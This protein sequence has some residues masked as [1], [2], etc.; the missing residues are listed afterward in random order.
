MINLL[1]SMIRRKLKSMDKWSVI[2]RSLFLMNLCGV[3]PAKVGSKV[4][5]V[6]FLFLIVNF[7]ITTY[8]MAMFF[9][10]KEEKD[11]NMFVMSLANVLCTVHAILYLSCLYYQRP[12][13]MQLLTEMREKFWEIDIYTDKALIEN[14][15]SSLDKVQMKYALFCFIMFYTALTYL[16][17]RILTDRRPIGDNLLFESYV[18]E[19]MSFWFLLAWQH[20]PA[21]AL[22]SIEMAMDFLICSI[23]SLTAQQYRLLRYEMERVF[24]SLERKGDTEENISKRIRRCNDQLTFLLSFRNTLNEAFSYLM[25]AY[26]GV[27]VLILC[28]EVYLLFQMDS[29]EHI[30]KI[31]AYSGFIFFEFFVCYCYPAQ[32]LTV[33]AEQLANSIYFSEWY[34]YPNHCKE[35]LMLVGKSQIRVVF[36]AGGLLE[37]DLPTGMAVSSR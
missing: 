24:G 4:Q 21:G 18:P 13:I 26:I 9:V 3:H 14:Y 37:L 34:K 8:W 27:V 6:V 28:F 2:N 32:D 12:S 1:L 20:I 33:D 29:I 16:Y 7:S 36:T 23:L 5:L 22:I 19:G 25:L 30:I 11:F 15:Q 17:W 35:I 31:L 10:V